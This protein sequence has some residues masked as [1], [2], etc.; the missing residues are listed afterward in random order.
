VEDVAKHAAQNLAP[1]KHP[2]QIFLVDEMPLTPTGKIAKDQLRKRLEAQ[3][4][5][6]K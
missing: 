1:Y 6:S 2:T 4:T 3:Q 5:A